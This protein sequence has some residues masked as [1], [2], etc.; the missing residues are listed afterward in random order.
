MISPLL[1]NVYFHLIDRIVNNPRSLFGKHGVRI[2]RY[3]DDFVLM[4]RTLP[5]EITGKLKSLLDRMGLTIN[6]TKTRQIDAREESFNFLGFTVRYDRDINDRSTK[7][8]N[9]MPSKKSEQKI[10]DKVKD[11]L[12]T[13]GHYNALDVADG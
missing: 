11:Y 10:R 6:E 1:A 13:H 8:W 4:G 12:L 7:Y 5:A 9:I 3:A 2:V